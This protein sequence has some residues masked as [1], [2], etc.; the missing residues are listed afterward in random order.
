[1][2]PPSSSQSGWTLIELLVSMSLFLVVMSAALTSFNAFSNNEARSQNL[3]DAQVQARVTM[4][5][6]AKELRNL[7]SPDATHQYSIEYATDY[8]LVF[9][10]VNPVGPADSANKTNLVRVRYCLDNSDPNSETLYRMVE[11]PNAGEALREIQSPATSDPMI[12]GGCPLA[13]FSTGVSTLN[14]E[15]VIGQ[16]V[17]NRRGGLDRKIFTYLPTASPTS[18]ISQVIAQIYMDVNALNKPPGEVNLV[19]SAFLRNQ[20]RKPVADIETP[21][22]TTANPPHILLNGTGS[23]DPEGTPVTYAWTV[24]NLATNATSSST[25]ALFD[26]TAAT[27]SKYSVRLIVT[28]SAGLPSDSATISCVATSGTTCP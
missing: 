15:R 25:K 6:M 27:A 19:T 28:D 16:Q 20:N 17:T 3:T 14:S 1:M 4:D 11:Q 23:Q 24:T 8:D 13:S 5:R 7:A 9:R 22:V 21:T 18:D 10:T 26:F 2:R 12:A